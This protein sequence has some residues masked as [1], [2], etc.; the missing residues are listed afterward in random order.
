MYRSEHF[1]IKTWELL[2]K[3]G[4]LTKEEYQLLYNNRNNAVMLMKALE[5]LCGEGD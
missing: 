1:I 3:R 2:Y 5:F 4:I